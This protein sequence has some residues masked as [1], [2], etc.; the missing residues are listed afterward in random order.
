MAFGLRLLV[1]LCAAPL[2]VAAFVGVAYLA[3]RVHPLYLLLGLVCVALMLMVGW[4]IHRH[5]HVQNQGPG[6]QLCV[7]GIVF[8]A[9][10]A[11]AYVMTLSSAAPRHMCTVVEARTWHR[12][13]PGGEETY[14]YRRLACDDGRTDWLGNQMASQR[15]T[16]TTDQYGGI[17]LRVAYDP[18]GQLPSLALDDQVW[19]VVGAG[20]GMVLVVALHVGVVVAD[21][22]RR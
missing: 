8:V 2:V 6:A 22:R 16:D 11:A 13:S 10:I 21:Q 3:L 7:S 4:H 17:R 5:F 1:A 19:W 20:I 18:N 9:T 15:G 14:N 12:L